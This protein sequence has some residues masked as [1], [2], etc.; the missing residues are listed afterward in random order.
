MDLNI[1]PWPKV[2]RLIQ[3]VALPEGIQV[4]ALDHLTHC[5]HFEVGR[6]GDVAHRNPTLTIEN[7]HVENSEGVTLLRVPRAFAIISWR[8]GSNLS[9]TPAVCWPIPRM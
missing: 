9:T 8:S 5:G 7:V 6:N 2:N 3:G 1:L 4:A